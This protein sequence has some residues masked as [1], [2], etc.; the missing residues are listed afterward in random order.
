MDKNESLSLI[1]E[2]D[3]YDH[4]TF[5]EKRKTGTPSGNKCI[6]DCHMPGDIIYHPQNNLKIVEYNQPFCATDTWYDDATTNLMYHDTC[7]Y[8]YVLLQYVDM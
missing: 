3:Y 6:T 4:I 2:L 7:M 8:V 1:E 5:P